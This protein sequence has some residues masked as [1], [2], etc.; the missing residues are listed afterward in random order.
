MKRKVSILLFVLV[1]VVALSAIW[2]AVPTIAEPM[3]N[4]PP[5]PPPTPGAVKEFPTSNIPRLTEE[6][7]NQAIA[8]ATSDPRVQKLLAGRKY[9]VASVG[10]WHTKGLKKI[11]AGI[12]FSFAEPV[13]FDGLDW[14]TVEYD[15]A[16]VTWPPY[17]PRTMHLT[18]HNTQG[19]IAMV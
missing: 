14:P 7:R 13:S 18:V 1:G 10:S 16:E 5:G 2:L 8:I 6:E 19:L 9:S 11:G 17:Q 15:E 3:Q 4:L 12:V